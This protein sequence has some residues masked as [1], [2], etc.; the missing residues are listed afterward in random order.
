MRSL[1]TARFTSEPAGKL[2]IK[3]MNEIEAAVRYCLGL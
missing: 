2:T 3:K 1:D